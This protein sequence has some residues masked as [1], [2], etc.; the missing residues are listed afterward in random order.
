MMSSS[1]TPVKHLK[2]AL[3]ALMSIYALRMLGIFMVLPI[4]SVYAQQL[5]DA[6]PKSIGLALGIYGLTQ[7]LF[8]LPLGSLSDYIGRQKVIA[9]GLLIF[10]L[11][12]VIAALATNLPSLIVGRAIQGAGA[13]GS[14]LM[15]YISDITTEKQRTKAMAFIGMTIG[16][17]FALALILGPLLQ[18]WIEVSGIF[19]LTAILALL[20]ILVTLTCLPKPIQQSSFT[21]FS[22]TQSLQQLLKN[23]ELLRL[24]IGI[25]IQHAIL[26]AS[27]VAIPLIFH[28]SLPIT[29]QYQWL[30]Y[31]IILVGSFICMFPL[32]IVA[33]KYQQIKK[34]FLIAITL[35]GIG[36]LALSFYQTNLWLF[37]LSLFIF[38]T[39]FNLLEALLPSLVSRIAPAENKGTALG[40]YSTSQFL[41]IFFGGSLGGWVYSHYP[42]SSV[43]YL[44][45]LLASCWLLMAS[46]MHPPHSKQQ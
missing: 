10:A 39:G 35:I 25:F 24:D 33:E 27:F 31:L 42:L 32:I 38:F 44:T 41:G 28:Q 17:S 26:T 34:I 4:F 36:Q 8:Q 15:A 9:G 19:W 22:F 29:K 37:S 1:N 40:I 43:F 13:I 2:F 12:S 46:Q 5:P 11:G 3:S 7:A 21:K 14:T 6:T 30:L 16:L 45:T 18:A 23:P 20:A